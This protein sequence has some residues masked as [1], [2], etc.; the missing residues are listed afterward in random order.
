M[1]CKCS[2]DGAKKNMTTVSRLGAV[3]TTGHGESIKKILIKIIKIIKKI[4]KVI[5]S[6]I[7]QKN[8]NNNKNKK[9]ESITKVC[10]AHRVVQAMQENPAN[11]VFF[12]SEEDRGR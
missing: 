4:K 6:K 8:K 10:L 11:Q 1:S 7:I 12:I 5:A 3:S 9:G 2:F